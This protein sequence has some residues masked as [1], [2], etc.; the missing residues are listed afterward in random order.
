[1]DY[2]TLGAKY[3]FNRQLSVA[4]EYRLNN[5]GA[6]DQFKDVSGQLTDAK[7]DMQLAMRYD[8]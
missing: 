7:D 3:Q 2:V 6:E 8:F 1:V 4:A 5:R